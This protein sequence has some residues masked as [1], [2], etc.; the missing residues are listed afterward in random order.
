MT[1]ESKAELVQGCVPASRMPGGF[2]DSNWRAAHCCN[3]ASVVVVMM[4]L[5]TDPSHC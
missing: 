3:Y 1:N 2:V 5:A 4:K